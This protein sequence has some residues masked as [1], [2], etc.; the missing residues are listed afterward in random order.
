MAHRSDDR[1]FSIGSFRVFDEVT[2]RSFFIGTYRHIERDRIARLAQQH[3]NL[4]LIN[5]GFFRKLLVGS[6]A[7]QGLIHLAL[8]AG[9]LVY[10]L[11]Q[12]DWEANGAGL[13]SHAAGNR[14]A[15]PPRGI[16]GELEAL[17][18]IELLHCAD[19]A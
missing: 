1:S 4:V 14:L 19:K 10:L 7:A 11:H 2:Q 5:T 16:S 9:K 12:V 3:L 15:D 18:V 8:N 6:F 17:G 13:V